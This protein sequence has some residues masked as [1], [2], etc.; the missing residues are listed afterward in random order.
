MR[1]GGNRS[2]GRDSAGTARDDA[3]PVSKAGLRIHRIFDFV[4][5]AIGVVV[6]AP[7]LLV[8]S[9]AVS[10]ESRGPVFVRQPALGYNNRVIGAFRFRLA[11][12]DGCGAPRQL[13]RVSQFLCAAGIDE[14]PQL[15]NVLR[16]EM[17][18]NGLLR[19][20][21]RDGILRP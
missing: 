12:V 14:L 1:S 15:F 10:L 13:T 16:G 3:E 8:T 17:S 2:A 6:F 19:S 18:I 9:I 20:A 5:A 7:I 4:A 11:K 21:L